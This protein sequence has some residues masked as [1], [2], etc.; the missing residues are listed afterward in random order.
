MTKNIL[1][2]D[3]EKNMIWA[4]KRALKDENYSIF[5][6]ADGEEAVKQV[7]SKNL[8]LVLLDLRMP[9]M[10]GM[11]AL[12]EIKKINADLPVI[13]ITAHGTMES[14]VEAMKI[15]ALDYISKP[16]DVDELKIQIRKAIDVGDMSRQIEFL[17]EELQNA[18]GKIIIGD[19]H[20]MKE[21]LEMVNRV[22]KSNATILITGE[23][24][25][26]KELIANAIHYS[27]DRSNKPYIKVNCGALPE[28]LLESE[29][30]GHE[31]G[32]FTGA[33]ER[34]IGR[35]ERADEG[36]IFLDEIGEISLAMQVKLLRVLQE[37]EIERVG[38]TETIKIDTRVIAATNKDLLEMVE[39]GEFR[40]DLYYR[41]NVIP[42][43]LPPLRERKEDIVSLV[44]YFLDKY[45]KEIG[46]NKM[47]I[48]KNA[49]DYLIDYKW[50]GNIRE[51]E[52]IIERL[53][54][55]NQKGKIEKTDLPKDILYQEQA[56]TDFT[57]PTEGINLEEVEQSLIRQALESTDYNQSK[58]AKLLGIT[59]HTLI[60][61]MDKYKIDSN[62]E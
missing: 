46:R 5:S 17:T 31:K 11:E 27:S 25:T 23:S 7:K 58:A 49:L 41:L 45:C 22:S 53:V 36:T 1:I 13:M 51:L 14:A 4:I 10:D 2:A 56:N 35:F 61:R 59:R 48:S 16:F 15:G 30:F 3:D 52:N 29:L 34:K 43:E 47:E 38:G 40:E 19:S 21:I 20:K 12:K 26:G 39:K 54:I 28:G 44:D 60:Y 42:I 32:A 8:Q 18:T 6:A 55:L 37:K 57:L 62:K 33:I 9:K 50:K 24:G